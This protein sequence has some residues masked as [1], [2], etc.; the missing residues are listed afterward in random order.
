MQASVANESANSVSFYKHYWWQ[1]LF[2][3]KVWEF[4][5]NVILDPLPVPPPPHP[6]YFLPRISI[7][8]TFY[9]WQGKTERKN[10]SFLEFVSPLTNCDPPSHVIMKSV[11][12]IVTTTRKGGRAYICM[13]QTLQHNYFLQRVICANAPQKNL[14]IRLQAAQ[15][16]A[17]KPPGK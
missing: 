3:L 16:N 15:R 2:Q 7:M 9:C 11:I 6:T 8:S 14:P 4:N 12:I 17:R 1:I 10:T 5:S 13:Q